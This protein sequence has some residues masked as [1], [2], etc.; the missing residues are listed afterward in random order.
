MDNPL[1][2]IATPYQGASISKIAKALGIS[3][4]LTEEMESGSSFLTSLQVEWM[5]ASSSHPITECYWGTGDSVVERESATSPC[6]YFL[7]LPTWDHTSIVKPTAFTD[8]RYKV[9]MARVK[10]LL[11]TRVVDPAEPQSGR[12]PLPAL[13]GEQQM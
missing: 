4:E 1:V 7:A 2:S 12:V 3:K 6:G 8:E 13:K 11:A 5:R 9:P 10:H